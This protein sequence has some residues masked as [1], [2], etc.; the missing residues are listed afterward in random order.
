MH[1]V[2]HQFGMCINIITV[3]F[4]KHRFFTRFA[5]IPCSAS[6][7]TS[8]NV[9]TDLAY[10]MDRQSLWRTGRIKSRNECIKSCSSMKLVNFGM[11]QNFLLL[12]II[13]QTVEKDKFN[14]LEISHFLVYLWRRREHSIACLFNFQL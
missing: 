10:A 4:F 1:H 14:A 11:F 8:E 6:R 5:L 2:V 7:E 3:F 13:L 12:N 9:D